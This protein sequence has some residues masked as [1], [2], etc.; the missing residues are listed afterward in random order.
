MEDW[1]MSQKQSVDRK[2]EVT[3]CKQSLNGVEV[4]LDDYVVV[5][6]AK[7]LTRNGQATTTEAN[8]GHS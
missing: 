2:A 3:Q 6:D 5:G 4:G 7:E 8:R 1:V